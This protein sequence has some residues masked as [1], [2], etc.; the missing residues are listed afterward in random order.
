MKEVSKFVFEKLTAVDSIL[1]TSTHFVL[2]KYKDHGTSLV[3]AKKDERM[4]VSA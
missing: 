4:V 3:E 2:K 1:S